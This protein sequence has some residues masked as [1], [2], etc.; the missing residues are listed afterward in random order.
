MKCLVSGEGA[1]VGM[2]RAGA[3]EFGDLADVAEVVGGPLI[4][5]LFKRDEAELG[6]LGCAGADVGRERSQ[7]LDELAPRVSETRQVFLRRARGETFGGRFVFLQWRRVFENEAAYAL[8]E[9]VFAVGEVREDFGDRPA[10]GRGLPARDIGCDAAKHR[11]ED[12]RRLFHKRDC[13]TKSGGRTG[14]HRR[15]PDREDCSRVSVDRVSKDLELGRWEGGWQ[16]L[17]G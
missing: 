1:C 16:R 8:G 11:F 12:L 14:L 13:G 9:A 17:S 6:M 5:H 4:E 3:V 15:P 2:E 7:K 10:I